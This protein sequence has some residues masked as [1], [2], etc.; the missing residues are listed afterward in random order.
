VNTP[1]FTLTL[2]E[3]AHSIRM[4]FQRQ[5]DSR[6]FHSDGIVARLLPQRAVGKTVPSVLVVTHSRLCALHL[7]LKLVVLRFHGVVVLNPFLD[8]ARHDLNRLQH[9]EQVGVI[10]RRDEGQNKK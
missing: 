2:S 8:G 9:L 7:L 3:A 5:T 1:L 10:A 4:E 6:G